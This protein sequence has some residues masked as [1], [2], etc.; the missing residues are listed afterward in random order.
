MT[1]Y[2]QSLNFAANMTSGGLV[3]EGTVAAPNAG[4]WIVNFGS[5]SQLNLGVTKALLRRESP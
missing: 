5:N 2:S 4:P 3:N 1:T